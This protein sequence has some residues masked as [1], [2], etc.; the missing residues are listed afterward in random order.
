MFEKFVDEDRNITTITVK[1]EDDFRKA[2]GVLKTFFN[3]NNT[4]HLILDLRESSIDT[5]TY[6]D[7]S[8]LFRYATARTSDDDENRVN[9]KTALVGSSDL[10]S[11]V[12]AIFKTCFETEDL[13]INV[14]VFSSEEKA[15][16]WIEEG[17]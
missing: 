8:D 2:M 5:I 11:E 14:S 13:P 15:F 16:S 3:D 4:E 12:E 1:W 9:G 10:K 7:V 17:R 6:D